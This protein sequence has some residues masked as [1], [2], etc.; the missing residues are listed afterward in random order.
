MA[1]HEQKTKILLNRRHCMQMLEI[2]T[3][4]TSCYFTCFPL[5]RKIRFCVYPLVTRQLLDPNRL[6]WRRA[7]DQARNP[8]SARPFFLRVGHKSDVPKKNFGSG[9]R[10]WLTFFFEVRVDVFVFAFF[11]QYRNVV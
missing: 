2:K 6:F 7:R 1:D 5:G 10:P 3:I 11:Y 8:G 4:P 9:L